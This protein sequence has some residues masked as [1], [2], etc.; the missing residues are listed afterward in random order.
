MLERTL[1]IIKPDAV[2]RQL[3]GRIISRFEEKGLKIVG[4]KLI[5][6]SL[7]QAQTL[8]AIH[9]KKGF[10]KGLVRFITSAPVV[11][12]VLEAREVVSIC[13][14]MIGATMGPDAEPGTIRGDFGSG[15]TYNLI[16]ASD[17]P[18]NANTEM[19]VFFTQN[20]LLDYMLN[21]HNWIHSP[22]DKIIS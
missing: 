18:E 9:K 4:L 21:T 1:V 8:Y 2:Q 5:S 7:K 16:H 14:K 3:A 17:S 10:Y 15:T 22:D 12:M 6:V 19:S 13:R 11:V 20:E